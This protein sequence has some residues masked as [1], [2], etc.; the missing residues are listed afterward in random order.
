MRTPLSIESVLADRYSIL[1]L[2]Y[3]GT[4]GWVYLA[5]DQTTNKFY[6][7]EETAT[8]LNELQVLFTKLNLR[9]FAQ[10]QDAIVEFDR[11]YLIRN[12]IEGHSYRELLE[13]QRIFS[14]AEVMRFLKQVLLILRSLHRLKIAHHSISLNSIIQR[15]D[16]SLILTEFT[17]TRFAET[18]DTDLYYLAVIAIVLLTGCEP[19]DLYNEA[20]GQWEWQDW[21]SINPRIVKVLDRMLSDQ[22]RYSSAA[23]VMQ[24]LFAPD[25]KDTASIVFTFV[26]IGLAAI[27]AYRLIN[28]L[29]NLQ[30][31]LAT[32]PIAINAELTPPETIA[33]RSKRLK[34]SQQ[35]LS[36]LTEET[37]QSSE[38]ILKQLE[39]LSQE[40]RSGM[41][42]YKR[43]NY[44]AWQSKRSSNISDRA[45]ETLTDAQFVALFPDQQG[46]ILNPRTFGQVWYAIALDQI[47]QA[48]AE[49]ILSQVS[50][51]LKQGAGRIYRSQFK[52]GQTVKLSLNASAGRIAIWM[53]S[54]ETS[55]IKN[56]NQ[57]TWSGKIQRSGVYELIVAPTSTTPVQ[58]ELQIDTAAH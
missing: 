38:A 4:V 43:V 25:Q 40:A 48:K 12:Y 57:S 8:D 54:A 13:Q 39:L 35:L 28:H 11:V 29:S 50:G 19:K 17:Q 41:G 44:D 30:P 10:Y 7:L 5:I 14:E 23:E 47:K 6:V 18:F 42:T 22:Q 24:A 2:L 58:Y 46:K 53:F 3:L 52:Q 21:E 20:T 56:S 1:K 26:L 31:E 15:E 16:G 55:L 45:I 34:V 27:S 33:Q 49:L 9:Y 36:Q 32:P 37:S 51:T